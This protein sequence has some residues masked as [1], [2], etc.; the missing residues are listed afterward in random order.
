MP[1]KEALKAAGRDD[2]IKLVTLAGG[3]TEVAQYLGLRARRR[4][5]GCLHTLLHS[6]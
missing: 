3:F 6:M 1:T 5:Q 4:P 2:L